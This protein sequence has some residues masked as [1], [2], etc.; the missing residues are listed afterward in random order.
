MNIGLDIDGVLL[1]QEKFQLQKG[2]KFF[3]KQYIKK[4]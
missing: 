3:K 1:N 2:I 4:Y